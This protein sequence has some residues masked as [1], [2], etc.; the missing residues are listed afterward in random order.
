MAEQKVPMAEPKGLTPNELRLQ[1]ATNK[2]DEYGVPAGLHRMGAYNDNGKRFSNKNEIGEE[3]M[4]A[5]LEKE[6]NDTKTF[7]AISALPG[8]E[9]ENKLKDALHSPIEGKYSV[10]IHYKGK[11]YLVEITPLHK[12]LL[13]IVG[14]KRTRKTRKNTKHE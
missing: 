13:P 14:G 5:K 9:L 7:H 12:E 2:K 6:S 4:R 3:L 11:E 10:G 1:G 8:M